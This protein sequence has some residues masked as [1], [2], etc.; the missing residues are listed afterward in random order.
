MGYL[1]YLD[2]LAGK[3]RGILLL[4]ELRE[5]AFETRKL[6]ESR[7]FEGRGIGQDLALSD[8]DYSIADLLH[9]FKHVG[10]IEDSLAFGRERLQ[11]VFEQT[12]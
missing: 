10:D 3:H 11:E 1:H 2:Q 8:N 7:E 12:S 6:H 9:H 5:H 4:N